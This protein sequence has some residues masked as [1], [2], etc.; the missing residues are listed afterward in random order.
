MSNNCELQLHPGG[1]VIHCHADNLKPWFSKV[2]KEWTDYLQQGPFLEA[3]NDEDSSS[4]EDSSSDL[5]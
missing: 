1:E 4:I 2:P 5:K 3:S